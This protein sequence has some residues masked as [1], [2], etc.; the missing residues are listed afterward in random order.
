MFMENELDGTILVLRKEINERD[1][2]FSMLDNVL[3]ALYE[4]SLSDVRIVMFG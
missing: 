4:T 3:R 1:I 2:I